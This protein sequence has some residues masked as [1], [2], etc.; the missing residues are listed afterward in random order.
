MFDSV[1]GGKTTHQRQQ[2]QFVLS[3]RFQMLANLADKQEQN[4]QIPH[5]CLGSVT[6][7]IGTKNIHKRKHCKNI[8]HDANIVPADDQHGLLLA[9]QEKIPLAGN[10]NETGTLD[11]GSEK[12]ISLSSQDWSVDNIDTHEPDWELM[13]TGNCNLNSIEQENENGEN[14]CQNLCNSNT[15]CQDNEKCIQQTGSKLGFVPKIDLKLYHGEIVHW[16]KVPDVIQSHYIIKN[17]GLPNFLKSRI[18][19]TTNL[20]I[21]NWR[22]YLKDWDQQLP[23]LLEYE[24]PLDFDR[25]CSLQSVDSNHKSADIHMDQVRS[26]IQE[27]LAHKAIIGPFQNLPPSF[28]ISPLMTRDKQDS[29]KKRTIMDLS[30]PKGASV[31]DGV[32]KGIYLGTSYTLHYPSVDNI[33]DTLCCLGPGAKL[34]KIDISRAFCHLRVDP[35]DIDLLVLQVD[36][37]RFLDVSTPFGYRNGSQFFQRCSDAIRYIMANHGFPDLFNYIVDLIYVGLPSKIDA[38]FAF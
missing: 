18:P 33:T 4:Q 24:F 20:N 14:S 15:I 31:N 26:Y 29:E 11:V 27:E 5:V 8:K 36:Q 16:D 12:I 17:S 13:L 9:Q 23:D 22:S 1:A 38:A 7:P 2:D 37:R 10:K 32:S 21:K 25:T 34:F 35:S 28:H 6:S 3:N 30:W 19:V